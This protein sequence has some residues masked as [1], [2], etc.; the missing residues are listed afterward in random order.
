MPRKTSSDD[1]V[2]GILELVRGTV[3]G[4]HPR[5][6]GS[7]R[8]RRSMHSGKGGNNTLGGPGGGFGGGGD[9]ASSSPTNPMRN[10]GS[11]I[12]GGIAGT[13]QELPIGPNGSVLAVVNG[14]VMWTDPVHLGAAPSYL[15]Y[16]DGMTSYDL[17]DDD[18]VPI[19]A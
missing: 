15:T 2:K 19:W 4:A 11:L 1:V 10:P 16:L 12:V 8:K 18:L 6:R 7:F 17:T 3:I 5:I 14:V 9:G 13:M